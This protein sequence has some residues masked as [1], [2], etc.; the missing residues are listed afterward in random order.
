MKTVK[1][2]KTNVYEGCL[3]MVHS[4]PS[5]IWEIFI[6]SVNIVVNDSGGCFINDSHRDSVDGKIIEI[7]VSDEFVKGCIERVESSKKFEEELKIFDSLKQ[8]LDLK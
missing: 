7:E 6:P 2:Y 1:L 8:N 3:A 4:M 5:T